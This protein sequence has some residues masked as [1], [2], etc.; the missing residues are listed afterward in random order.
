MLDFIKGN[1]SEIYEGEI[2]LDNNDIGY[3]ISISQLDISKL[4]LNEELKIYLRLILREDNISLYGFLNKDSRTLFDLLNTV[5]SVGPKLSMTILGALGS[6]QLRSAI[7]SEDA[8]ILTKSP[9]VG[10]KTA[11]RIIL[12]LKDK[13]S[14]KSFTEDLDLS[15]LDSSDT[16]DINND[17]ALEALLSL[18]YNEYE[19]KIALRNVDQNQEL[20]EIIRQ[21]LKVM[22]K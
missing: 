12:E 14:K 17:P 2:V 1:I 13:I 7:L 3:L 15:I 5:S 16:I 18:G 11:N 21:A 6:S 19:A 22:A 10:K 9:G 4:S 20:S 8:N